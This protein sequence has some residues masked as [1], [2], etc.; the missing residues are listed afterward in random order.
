MEFQSFHQ[1]YGENPNVFNLLYIYTRSVQVLVL[2]PSEYSPSNPIGVEIVGFKPR[3][4]LMRS[5]RCTAKVF[6]P[7]AEYYVAKARLKHLS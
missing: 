1:S 3:S 5:E 2:V 6:K 7:S 4:Q